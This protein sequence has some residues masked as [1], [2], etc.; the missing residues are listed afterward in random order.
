MFYTKYRNK[1]VIKFF[2]IILVFFSI[3]CK[4]LV[5]EDSEQKK[6]DKRIR[7]DNEF[8]RCTNNI[9]GSLHGDEHSAEYKKCSDAY[10]RCYK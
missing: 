1:V 2:M 7:C 4:G 10:N 5:G 6:I 9:S 3:S 8:S